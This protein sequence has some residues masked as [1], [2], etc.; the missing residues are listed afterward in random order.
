MFIFRK[1]WHPSLIFYYTKLCKNAYPPETMTDGTVL[2][3]FISGVHNYILKPHDNALIK[4]NL[5]IKIP[6]IV[7]STI[8]KLL[9]FCVLIIFI[10]KIIQNIMKYNFSQL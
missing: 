10:M 7:K 8:H 9:L 1:N 4:T 3:V 2:Q 6:E 5:A